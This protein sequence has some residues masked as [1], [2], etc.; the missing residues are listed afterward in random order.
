[1]TMAEQRVRPPV[2]Y[3]IPTHLEVEDKII[4]YNGIG[5]TVRQAFVLVLGWSL[6]VDVWRSLDG[7]A[8]LGM[9]GV[10]LRLVVSAAPGL[11]AC[12][13]AFTRVGGRHLESW[14]LVVLLYH[15]KP[16]VYLWRA[17][18]TQV[19]PATQASQRKRKATRRRWEGDG[20]DD[21]E[22]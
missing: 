15:T 12:F 8:H 19:M 14:L 4:S 6:A 16:K 2:R 9:A 21:D 17:L 18:A 22:L 11:L 3:Q 13:I 10:V 1:M 20:F 5:I 7:L